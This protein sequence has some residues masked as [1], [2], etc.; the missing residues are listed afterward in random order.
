MWT[1][2]KSCNQNLNI[3]AVCAGC[4]ILAVDSKAA[5]AQFKHKTSALRSPLPPGIYIEFL[6]MLTLNGL[7]E[8]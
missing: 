3:T 2:E 4:E 6:I 1:N 5:W 7:L 8:T